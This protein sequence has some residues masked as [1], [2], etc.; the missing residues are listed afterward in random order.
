AFGVISHIVS[1][2]SNRTIFGY[3]GMVYAMISIGIL[4][5]IVWAHH[6]FTVGLDVDTRAYFTAA[7]MIIA[8]PTGIKIFSWLATMWGG[9]IRFEVPMLFAFGFIFL[10]TIGG[11]TGLVLSNATLDIPLHDTYYVVGH[12][13]YVLSMG[14]VFGVFAGWYY[15]CDTMFGIRYNTLLGKIHFYTFFIGVNVTFFPMHFLGLAGMPRRIADYPDAFAGWN[16]ISSIGSWISIFSL[17]VFIYS[18]YYNL[19]TRSHTITYIL[20][21]KHE[22]QNFYFFNNIENWQINF[23]DPATKVMYNIINFH[24][25]L[26]YYLII[27]AT[28]VLYFLIRIWWQFRI[29]LTTPLHE[30]DQDAMV[31]Y[32]ISHH[33]MLEIIWTIIPALILYL[34]A[35][36]SFALLY[37]TDEDKDSSPEFTIKITGYQWYWNYELNV[38]YTDNYSPTRSYEPFEMLLPSPVV[39]QTE[40]CINFDSVVKPT[41]E[42]LPSELRLLSVDR[43]VVFPVNSLLRLIITAE[44]V[45]HSWTIPA[46]GV[47]VDAIPGRL[48]AVY[49]IIER[50]GIFYGQCSEICGEYHNAMP[51]NISV[52]LLSQFWNWIYMCLYDEIEFSYVDHY[53][54]SEY[55]V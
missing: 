2:Y 10:F 45:I 1:E 8:V 13:H 44:D 30:K 41:E 42:L 38:P 4:G 5:F 32:G 35:I 3:L 6:M 18:L 37:S 34:I 33:Q 25:D 24:H 55:D 14:A 11:L 51:I 36:P 7:T 19:T 16:M 15:W 43:I 17:I 39:T 50:I 9:R 22:S 23:N 21:N 46:F 20:Q 47:K 48:N 12:F 26:M 40:F 54:G 28:I 52:A 31:E 53:K 27:I 29:P 49:L